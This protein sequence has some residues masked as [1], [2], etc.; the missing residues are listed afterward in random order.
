MLII[1]YW[2]QN[3]QSPKWQCRSY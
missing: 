1:I 2:G 3:R